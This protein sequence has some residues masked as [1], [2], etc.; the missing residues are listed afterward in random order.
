[1]AVLH[2]RIATTP[3]IVAMPLPSR[4]TNLRLKFQRTANRSNYDLVFRSEVFK[5]LGSRKEGAKRDRPPECPIE[6]PEW[7][8]SSVFALRI[9]G[10]FEPCRP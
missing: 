9:I 8:N 2:K 1:M 6:T 7:V 5:I 10:D 4:F 3:N